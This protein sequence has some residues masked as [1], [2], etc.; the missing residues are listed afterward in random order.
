[1]R[2]LLVNPLNAHAPRS[3][4]PGEIDE[5]AG[6]FLPLGL[7]YV[8]A[9]LRQRSHHEVKVLDMHAAGA[10]PEL[11]RRAVAAEKPDIAGFYTTS[12]N[13][14]DALLCAKAAR[15][16]SPG[17]HVTFGGPHASIYPVE[18]A[19]H[20]AVDSLVIGEGECG[21]AE[22]ADALEGARPLRQVEGIAFREQGKVVCTHP[23]PPV[24]DLDSLP[25]PDRA[26]LDFRR[27]RNVLA[28]DFPSTTMI[29]SRGCPYR[30]EFC[31]HS[32]LGEE[33][34]FRTAGNVVDEMAECARLGIRDIFFYD[35]TFTAD[36]DRTFAVCRILRERGL[37]LKWS[38][39][40]RVD[41]VDERMCRALREAGCARIQFG[42]ESPDPRVLAGLGKAVSPG[43]VKEAFAWA[44][45][46]GMETVAYFM[47]GSPGESAG[48]IRETVAF[49]AKLDPDYAHFS[50]TMPFPATGL[51]RRALEQKVIAKDVWREFAA[52]GD[53]SFVPPYWEESLTAEELRSLLR[54]AYRNFYFRPGYILARAV[55][56]GP[57][58]GLGKKLAMA[59]RLLR[60]SFAR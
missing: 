21:F 12:F 23:R 25:F 44:R 37:K 38:V 55:R 35:D 3:N 30:C 43:K 51:Y 46:A 16:A 32:H 15:E 45:N 24:R 27:Y 4:F 10:G 7:L 17:V 58:R 22:L 5:K 29:S 1:M 52:T 20:P 57:A 41:A 31:Y 8:A 36:R 11:L 28:Q 48:D 6:A 2:I 33:A 54:Y 59:G 47:I 42:I 40:T 26:M 56:Q 18:T 13:L 49:A 9:Y 14:V 53:G 19:G 34:R 39:R 50:I 60:F